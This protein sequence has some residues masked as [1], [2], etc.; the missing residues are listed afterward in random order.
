MRASVCDGVFSYLPLSIRKST[1]SVPKSHALQKWY[2]SS[3][4]MITQDVKREQDISMKTK[5]P[6]KAFPYS[7]ICTSDAAVQ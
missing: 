2:Q 3:K 7:E 6:L 1:I 5:A 4:S